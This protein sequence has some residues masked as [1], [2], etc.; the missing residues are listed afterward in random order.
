MTADRS[1]DRRELYRDREQSYVKHLIL[2][3][4]LERFAHIIGS[5]ADCI[6]YV[7]GFSGPWQARSEDLSD[8]SFA[9]AI[10]ELR[11][12]RQHLLDTQNKHVSLRCF[13]VE[14]ENSAFKQLRAFS[15]SIHDI[16][17]RIA[18]SEFE[19]AIPQICSFIKQPS[20]KK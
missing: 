8:T 10:E 2:R 13:F 6:T 20:G 15:E 18:N 16:E 5:W 4:Y 14:S 1:Q 19:T 9:I 12:A 7:D 3:I 17:I 11:R